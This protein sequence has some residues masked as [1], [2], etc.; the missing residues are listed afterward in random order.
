MVTQYTKAYNYTGHGH[1]C[2]YIQQHTIPPP[3][4][5]LY[6][7]LHQAILHYVD[8]LSLIMKVMSVLY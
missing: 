3:W 8:I 6:E 7:L 4:H 1:L 5:G 2:L